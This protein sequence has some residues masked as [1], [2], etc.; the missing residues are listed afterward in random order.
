MTQNALRGAGGG[1]GSGSQH[2]P[3]ESPDSLKS[4]ALARIVDVIAE[5]ELGGFH[6]GISGA[7][8]DIYLNE[9]CVM[10][11]DK[12]LNFQNVQIDSRTGT[13]DPIPRTRLQ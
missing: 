7:L 6:H 8:Q 2:T 13:A 3:T 1:G 9:T 4:T 5:G 10:N 11:A 12:S